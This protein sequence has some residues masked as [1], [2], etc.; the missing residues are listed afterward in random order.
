[1]QPWQDIM[2][3]GFLQLPKIC[4]STPS[5]ACMKV[6]YG[7]CSGELVFQYVRA[8]AQHLT[9]C[10]YVYF[11]CQPKNCI[12]LYRMIKLFSGL[13]CID[14]AQK[15]VSKPEQLMAERYST[16]AS[17]QQPLF[18]WCMAAASR[19]NYWTVRA[20]KLGEK[21]DFATSSG[22]AA[23]LKWHTVLEKNE[24]GCVRLG[25]CTCGSYLCPRVRPLFLFSKMCWA[26]RKV[27]QTVKHSA[28]FVF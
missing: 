9:L 25:G 26:L 1:M 2:N 20:D 11:Q 19:K 3:T 14:E 12:E 7:K 18:R 17:S 16:I 23:P 22:V 4:H 13:A 8:K 27:S 28:T 5:Q 6:P 10:T 24:W 21:N 15:P